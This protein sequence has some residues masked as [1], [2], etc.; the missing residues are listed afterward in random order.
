MSRSASRGRSGGGDS[1]G[2]GGV[3]GGGERTPDVCGALPKPSMPPS[4]ELPANP[5]AARPFPWKSLPSMAAPPRLP[6]SALPSLPSPP[7]SPRAWYL[8]Y[9]ATDASDT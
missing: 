2:A 4:D 9:P 8:I 6:G 3:C 1:K 5:P 7:S